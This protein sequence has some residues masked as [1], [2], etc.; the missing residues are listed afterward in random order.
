VR[1]IANVAEE[2]IVSVPPVIETYLRVAAAGDLDVLVGCFTEDAV[3]T[4]DGK[5]H[6]GRGE[7]ARWRE[8]VV[9]AF[10]YTTTVV[11]SVPDGDGHLV[12]AEVAGNFPGSPVRLKYRFELAGDLISRLV[13]A[14]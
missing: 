12:V 9:T 3:V 13:I 8:D 5:T 7:I 11:E 1:P 6:R 2:E 4:D 10:E 14:P